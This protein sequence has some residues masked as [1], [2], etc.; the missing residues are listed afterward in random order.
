MNGVQGRTI[1]LRRGG[2]GATRVAES[3]TENSREKTQ[4]AQ[5]W[6]SPFASFASFGGNCPDR[7]GSR[8]SHRVAVSRS[9]L[10][11]ASAVAETALGRLTK[12]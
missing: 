6:E 9:D 11:R 7:S 2:C 10:W 1:R 8:Q 4:N 12:G 5:E 3:N